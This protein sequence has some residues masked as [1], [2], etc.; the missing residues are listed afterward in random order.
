ME[1]PLILRASIV[2]LLLIATIL[3]TDARFFNDDDNFEY[4]DV[5]G[6]TSPLVPTNPNPYG[7]PTLLSPP[8]LPSLSPLPSP[9]LIPPSPPFTP[10]LTP[11]ITVP[12][13][14]PFNVPTKSP[15]ISFPP[16]PISPPSAVPVLS[17][18]ISVPGPNPPISIPGPSPPSAFPGPSLPVPALPPP[19]AASPPPHKKPESGTWCVAKPT[20]PDSVI[21]RALDYACGSGADCKSLQPNGPCFEPNTLLGHASYAFNSYWQSTKENGGTCDFGGTAMLVTA[22]PSYNKC[23]FI[24]K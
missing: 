13:S 14:P 3:F 18:P 7:I 12:P 2:Y 8:P 24:F 23:N 22:D 6:S 17:P 20:V 9:A 10:P 16:K 4:P 15:P 11:S 1:P 21:Q 19:V 5:L